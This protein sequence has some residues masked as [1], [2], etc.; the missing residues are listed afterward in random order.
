MRTNNTIFHFFE[1]YC[2]SNQEVACYYLNTDE[3]TLY[4]MM[5]YDDDLHIDKA[6][7]H[8]I[9][10]KLAFDLPK[11]EIEA[12]TNAL[13][14]STMRLEAWENSAVNLQRGGN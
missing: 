1:T 4:D 7:L 14:D 11:N 2:F 5:G 3:N 9:E 13:R 10:S 8:I 12:L 6:Y